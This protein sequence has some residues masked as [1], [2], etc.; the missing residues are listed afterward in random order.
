MMNNCTYSTNRFQNDFCQFNRHM[1]KAVRMCSLRSHEVM[2]FSVCYFITVFLDMPKV[3][4]RGLI[5]YLVFSLQIIYLENFYRQVYF[6][7]DLKGFPINYASLQWTL[8]QSLTQRS[9]VLLTRKKKG[10]GGALVDQ[11]CTGSFAYKTP[12]QLL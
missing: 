8:S 6:F 4:Y 10:V 7:K 3:E 12:G 9:T 2:G 5:L 11:Q 1:S